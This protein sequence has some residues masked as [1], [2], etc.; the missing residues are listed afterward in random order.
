MFWLIR[1]K[2]LFFDASLAYQGFSRRQVRNRINKFSHGLFHSRIEKW[3]KA[4]IYPDFSVIGLK[5]F[6]Q[7]SSLAG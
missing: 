6:W 4:K 7:M 1:L 3:L 5:R 2:D